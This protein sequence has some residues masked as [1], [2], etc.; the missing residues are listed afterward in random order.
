MTMAVSGKATGSKKYVLIGAGPASVRA[1][2]T[3]RKAEPYCTITMIGLETEPP[4]SRMALPYYISGIVGEE[5]THLRKT[6]DHFESLNIDHIYAK[7]EK[8]N[9][10]SNQVTLDNGDVYDYDKLL[11]ATGSRPATSPFPG[12]DNEGV[13]SCWTLEDGRKI[14]DTIKPGSK[15]AL[16][17]AGFVASIIIHPLLKRGV[18][19][20][21]ML[22]T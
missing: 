12:G 22:I 11:I 19:L 18:D 7:V 16:L 5:G 3:L 20:T 2:E 14:L 9:S 21:V 15:V 6:D 4:Y 10:E 8:I 17:G 1:A 13:V